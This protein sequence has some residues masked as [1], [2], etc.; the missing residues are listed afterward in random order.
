MLL[1]NP[2]VPHMPDAVFAHPSLAA[3]YDPLD[4]DRSD[5]DA[6]LN[7]VAEF[8]ARSVLDIG[9]GT[10]TFAIA[11]AQRGI[12]VTG[13]DPAAAS[14]DVAR[15]KP[16]A[17]AVS[18]L[19]GTAPDAPAM[20]VDLVVMTANVAQV[21]LT[22]D[23]WAATLTAAH[24]RLHPGGR[25]VFETR[26]P[27]THIWENWNPTTT[28]RVVDIPGTGPV[29]T[30]KEILDVDGELITF[31]Q[32][33]YFHRDNNRVDSQSTLRFRTKPAIQTSLQTAGFTVDDVRDA[34]D[35]PGYEWVFVA[36]KTTNS[37]G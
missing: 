24:D 37:P 33:T 1:T 11:L 25:L 31:K 2:N 26:N 32:A 3:V 29:E 35:R 23:D 10:G 7:M 12:N 6:Y 5:L 15:Q 8:N 36:R 13:V 14:L 34:P 28:R 21:F 9:C 4:P 30:W 27:A 19:L 17:T 22:D 16:G 20:Q 18:W